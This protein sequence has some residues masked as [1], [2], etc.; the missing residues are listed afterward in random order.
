MIGFQLIDS[1]LAELIK[2]AE[3]RDW[4]RLVTSARELNQALDSIPTGAGWKR[5]LA[6]PDEEAN[7][8]EL[9]TSEGPIFRDVAKLRI[10]E[11]R[12]DS[13]RKTPKYRALAEWPTLQATHQNLSTY[14]D[15]LVDAQA[16][17]HLVHD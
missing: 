4:I 3:R 17:P 11:S 5:Y 15:H 6:L 14:V 16:I 12:F 7:E 2:P 10:V 1:T 13:I 9:N 8:P